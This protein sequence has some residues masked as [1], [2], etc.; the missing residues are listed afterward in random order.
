MKDNWALEKSTGSGEVDTHSGES[1][2]SLSH[3]SQNRDIPLSIDYRQD[4][5]MQ[6]IADQQPDP[7]TIPKFRETLRSEND[8][9][10]LDGRSHQ[11]LV[12]AIYFTLEPVDN[13]LSQSTVNS[14]E[15]ESQISNAKMIDHYETCS[16]TSS[17]E[18]DHTH[19]TGDNG[20]IHEE[21]QGPELEGIC[22][23]AEPSSGSS[24]DV[25]GSRKVSI[26]TN[27]RSQQPISEAFYYILEPS[28]DPCDEV[29]GQPTFH[30][31]EET[32][33]Q[34]PSSP[35]SR[36]LKNLFCYPFL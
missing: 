19:D 32:T 27:E 30:L 8:S 3:S 26:S 34:T 20:S 17:C 28:S 16:P 5:N 29:L 6:S 7:R 2:D 25:Y 31:K 4:D 1:S 22:S 36:Q 35:N 15:T 9:N 13:T 12:N 23:I 21:I 11:P 10:C 24:S 33:S 18:S 14:E